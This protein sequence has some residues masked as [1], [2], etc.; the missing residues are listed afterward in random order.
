MPARRARQSRPE[1]GGAVHRGQGSRTISPRSRRPRNTSD[2]RR[3]DEPP[4]RENSRV[5]PSISFPDVTTIVLRATERS[6]PPSDHQ[7]KP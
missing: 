2:T 1:G 6:R 4:F 3:D 7:P 5:R